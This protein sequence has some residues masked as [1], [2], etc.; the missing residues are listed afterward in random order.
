MMN[1]RL[2]AAE[3]PTLS[4]SEVLITHLFNAPR[5]AVY[6]AWTDP[7]QLP[8]WFA[9]PDCTI[10]FA[11]LEIRLGGEFHSCITTPDGHEC[12]CRGN[13]RELV[14]PERIVFT[15]AVA[16]KA[17]NLLEPADAGMDSEWPRETIVEVTLVEDAGRTRLTLRQSVSETVA[18]RTGA[19]PSWILMFERLAEVIAK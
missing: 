15:M 2:A 18:K 9:P 10:R 11:K 7:A 4:D 5:G 6:R 17:G 13:Y 3:P 19:H 14:E 1:A 12:W 8:L 16:D